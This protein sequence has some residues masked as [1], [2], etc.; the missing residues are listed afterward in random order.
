MLRDDGGFDYKKSIV[1]TII[2]II[3]ENSD[4]KEAGLSHLCE[5]I[6]DCEHPV[7]ATRIL[8]LLGREARKTASPSRYIHFI[9]N[10]V[11][12]EATQVHAAA[13]SALAKFGAQCP[14]L[15]P[16]ILLL[17]KRC[18]LDR[19]DE[20][21]DRATYFLSILETDNPHLIA[22]YILNGLQVS[23]LGLERVLEQ[24]VTNGEYDK[25]FDL[26][27]VSISALPLSVTE[28]KKPSLS[29]ETISDKRRKKSI[30][31]RDLCRTISSYSGVCQLGPL[32]KSSQPIALT[33]EVTE[34]SV[35]CVK[36]IFRNISSCSSINVYV[37]LEQA[38][39]T[40]GWTVL[41]TIPLE[42]LPFGI[43]STTFILLKIPSAPDVVTAT[44]SASLKFKVRDID[45]ATGE[46]EGDESYNDVFV[47]EEIEIIFADYV[48]PAKRS[49]FAVSWEQIDDENENE[50]TYSLST[51]HT[52]CGKRKLIKCVGLWPCE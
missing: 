44:F 38:P 12:L 11:N 42:K 30:S 13:V 15:R 23:V 25:P 14:D 3:D 39:D 7:L 17:L 37:E 41:H 48:Q 22:N 34:Y 20:V 31:G 29:V 9:Y 26:K 19:N 35:L 18:L 8:H 6:E 1:D 2:T 43:Q 47:L 10:R 32:F 16:S 5:F 51:V 46:L 4:A 45:P 24:Y 36:H 27:V 33:D 50:D 52:L 21:R 28:V 40:E 49:N